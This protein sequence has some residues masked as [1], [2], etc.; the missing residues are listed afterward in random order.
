M[1][2]TLRAGENQIG[3]PKH[4]KK[5]RKEKD[6]KT[7]TEGLALH[8][9]R[10]IPLA[11]KTEPAAQQAEQLPTPAVTV[12]VGL[13]ALCDGKNQRNE[14]AQKPQPRKQNIEKPNT[15]YVREA[16]QR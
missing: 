6:Q 8:P 1:F 3:V 16:I 7:V 11:G 2:Q 10:D 4:Q 13:C 14:E 12:A 15:R 5:H 9:A